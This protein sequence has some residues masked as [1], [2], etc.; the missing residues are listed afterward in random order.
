M[1]VGKVGAGGLLSLPASVWGC[2]G[3]RHTFKNVLLQTSASVL[4]YTNELSDA[5]DKAR[6]LSLAQSLF[7]NDN[8][9]RQLTLPGMKHQRISY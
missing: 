2:A 8:L 7:D 5:V 3:D 1:Q 4:D 9:P 6:M